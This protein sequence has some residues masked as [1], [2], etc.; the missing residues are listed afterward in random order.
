[1]L[2]QHYL[3][4]VLHCHRFSAT[5]SHSNPYIHPGTSRSPSTTSQRPGMQGTQVRQ[6]SGLPSQLNTM[7]NKL[8]MSRTGKDTSSNKAAAAHIAGES[9]APIGSMSALLCMPLLI[10]VVVTSMSL[11]RQLHPAGVGRDDR[12]GVWAGVLPLRD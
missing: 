7:C 11:C 12:A 1:M 6:V 2:P 8:P 9:P 4:H 3:H 5:P 10:L